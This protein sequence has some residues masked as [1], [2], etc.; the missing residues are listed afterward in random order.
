MVFLNALVAEML[1]ETVELET[2]GFKVTPMGSMR[3]GGVV[4]IIGW[5]EDMKNRPLFEF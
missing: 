4:M 5:E 1:L 3:G 2:V